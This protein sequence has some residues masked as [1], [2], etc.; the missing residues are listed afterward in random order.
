MS[1][2]PS[3][4]A[5]RLVDWM[6]AHRSSLDEMMAQEGSRAIHEEFILAEGGTLPDRSARI[7]RARTASARAWMRHLAQA[8]AAELPGTPPDLADRLTAWMN[9]NGERLE[10]LVLEEQAVMERRGASGDPEA[11]RRDAELAATARLFAEGYATVT[12]PDEGDGPPPADFARRVAAWSRAAEARR[13]EVEREALAAWGS[14]PDQP[15]MTAARE[16]APE[17]DELRV[18]EAAAVWAHVRTT[19]EAL[20]ATLAAPPE[21]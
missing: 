1:A 14:A 12:A 17:P 15:E 5:D 20:E 16:S 21:D 7:A 19:A 3:G 11:D 2:P 8:L 9:A 18:K 13:R 10:A 4:L 6:A